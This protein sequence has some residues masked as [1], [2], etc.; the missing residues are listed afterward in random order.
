MLLARPHWGQRVLD[1]KQCLPMH[2]AS[3]IL[4]MVVLAVE[5]DTGGYIGEQ[6][7]DA[8][9]AGVSKKLGLG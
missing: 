1:D 4:P 2:N 7:R 5:A 8:T 9:V 3:V 6:N